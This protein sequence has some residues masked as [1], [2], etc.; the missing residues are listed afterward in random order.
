[1][2]WNVKLYYSPIIDFCEKRGTLSLE[3]LDAFIVKTL[4]VKETSTYKVVSRLKKMGYITEE[5]IP[6][7]KIIRFVEDEENV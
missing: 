5:K 1:M 7:K 2:T 6:A 3:E 4:G